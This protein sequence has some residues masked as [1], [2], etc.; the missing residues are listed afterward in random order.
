MASVA[1]LFSEYGGSVDRV[2]MRH[3][4]ECT[5]RSRDAKPAFNVVSL[6]PE[7]NMMDN[8]CRWLKGRVS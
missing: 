5:D 8:L 2:V 1:L 4:R 6:S 7:A 3:V